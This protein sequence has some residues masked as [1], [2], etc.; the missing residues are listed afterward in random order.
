MESVKKLFKKFRERF[1]ERSNFPL[2]RK[3]HSCDP[4]FDQNR[5]S[6][7]LKMSW[8]IQDLSAQSGSGIRQTGKERNDIR[9]GRD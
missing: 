1:L 8:G 5:D 6:G 2:V 4:G 3:G 9:G 7:I